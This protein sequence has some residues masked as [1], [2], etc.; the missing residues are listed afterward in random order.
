MITII[1][2]SC[3]QGMREVALNAEAI[4]EEMPLN[5]LEM[6]PAKISREIPLPMP[7]SV[8]RSPI[9]IAKAVPPA[10]VMPTRTWLNQPAFT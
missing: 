9:H 10:M 3:S 5:I 6:I 7:F 4:M 8:M 2:A 1:A